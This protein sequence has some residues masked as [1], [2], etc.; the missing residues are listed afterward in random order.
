MCFFLVGYVVVLIGFAIRLAVLSNLFVS[1]IFFFSSVFVFMGIAIEIRLLSEIQKTLSGLLPIC[2]KCKKVHE[3]GT[4]KNDP[5]SWKNI[6]TYIATRPNVDLT[7]GYCPECYE[8][9]IKK[10][11]IVMAKT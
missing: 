9:I 8:A 5:K 3:S 6:E 11:D 4:D 10:L 2:A 1:V 7:H